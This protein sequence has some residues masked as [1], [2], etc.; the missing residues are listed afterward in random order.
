[1]IFPEMMAEMRRPMDFYKGMAMA[2]ILIFVV[3]LMYGI[4][5]KD[6]LEL[7]ICPDTDSFSPTGYCFQGQYTQPNSFQGCVIPIF[8]TIEEANFPSLIVSRRSVGRQLAMC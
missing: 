5:C 3:Y 1:M 6:F 4:F 7:M 8:S 2:Q